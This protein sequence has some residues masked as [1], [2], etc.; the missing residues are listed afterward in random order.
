MEGNIISKFE[1]HKKWVETIGKE[2][3]MLRLDEVDLRSFDLSDK[4]VEQASLIE[5]TFD[6]LKLE[7][8]DFHTSLLCSSTFKNAY[9]DKCD[10]YKS[11]LRYTNFSNCVIKNS[12]FS[13]GDCWEAIFR[14]ANLVDCNLINVLFYLTD[15]S[16][17]RL[18]NVDISVATFEETLFNGVTLKNIKGI[19]EAHFESINIGTLEKPILLKSEKAKEWVLEKCE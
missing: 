10:F 4:L 6:D 17:A 5:C 7:N 3:E 11:D 16:N 2:G 19:E 9:L 1:L 12:R 15:F 14:N 13:K 8:I 18:E